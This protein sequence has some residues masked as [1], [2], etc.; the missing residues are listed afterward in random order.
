MQ[1]QII[2]SKRRL[3][4]PPLWSNVGRFLKQCCEQPMDRL[5]SLAI[6]SDIAKS[7]GFTATAERMGLSKTMVT[8][9]IHELE[10][11]LG[12]RLLQRTT[13]RVALTAAGEQCL[14]HAHQMLAVRESLEAAVGPGDGE[15]RGQ[16]RLT[17]AGTFAQAHMAAL[18]AEFLAA[19][20]LLRIDLHTG[21]KAVNLLDERIDL[22]LRI[23]SAPDP[24]L[25]G[26][27]L[28]P[29]PSRLVASPRYLS[30]MGLPVDPGD[31]PRHRCLGHTHVGKSEW[32]LRRADEIRHVHVECMLTANDALVL[33]NAAMAGAG[34]AMLPTY[35]IAPNLR[36]GELCDV[37]PD[38]QP[39]TLILF[40][41]YVTRINQ[42]PAVRSLLDYFASRF[43]DPAWRAR[44]MIGD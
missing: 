12:T 10:G 44:L 16:L 35:L 24:A 21:E 33:Q 11:W 19:H 28:A 17:A 15:L 9:A 31:L 38:W 18:L 37:L 22:A 39:P 40:G 26:R 7:G 36:T 13:R 43:S 30:Q 4:K 42:S 5:Q 25:L 34:I 41:L 8:R 29:I 23:S 20:P 3:N 14:R 27:P 1:S 2:V 32:T 6:F